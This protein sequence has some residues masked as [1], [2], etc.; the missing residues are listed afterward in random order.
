MP[1]ISKRTGSDERA[2][3]LP[4]TLQP[5]F[6]DRFIASWDL[7]E[8]YVARLACDILR[9]TGLEEAFQEASTISDAI[10]RAG[11]DTA[12]AAIPA[13]WLAATLA[14]RGSMTQ[15]SGAGAE[16]YCA[17]TPILKEDP[18]R[19]LRGAGAARRTLSA[20]LCHR[21][22]GRAAVPG[23]SSWRGHRRAG[24]VRSGRH[25]RLGQVFFQHQSAVCDQQPGR[26]DRGGDG[27]PRWRSDSGARWRT[28]Q[29][30]AVSARAAAAIWPRGV[31]LSF[32]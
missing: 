18:R 25:Q 5:L 13:R 4:P 17:A 30:R 26:R 23:R 21:R 27:L 22:A 9:T 7:F 10:A 12:V 19:D 29:R 1:V 20:C 6:D 8:E 28:G 24:A 15:V 31:A 2:A 16:R 32:H 14:A 3:L 11:L